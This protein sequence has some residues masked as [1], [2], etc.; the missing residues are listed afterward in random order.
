MAGL[1]IP[2]QTMTSSR[3]KLHPSSWTSAT[4]DLLSPIC[5]IENESSCR[6]CNYMFST[7]Y[8]IQ[9][10]SLSS[11]MKFLTVL[12]L[13][14]L[15]T[16]T[17]C[18]KCPD[19]WTLEE[20]SL[21]DLTIKDHQTGQNLLKIASKY[22][23]RT[24]QI[25]DTDGQVIF[26]EEVPG[27]G[28]VVFAPLPKNDEYEVGIE[29]S[30]MLFIDLYE[31]GTTIHDVDTLL[32]NYQVHLDECSEKEFTFMHIHYNDSLV[33]TKTDWNRFMYI[34]GFK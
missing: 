12:A 4:T 15:L 8:R 23:R 13:L 2:C 9:K 33:Y 10:R 18:N 29:K 21:I 16:L 6:F 25:R 31:A 26:D 34:T 22:D 17:S 28:I 27:D 20:Y 24:F 3:Y 19:D 1:T 7:L 11:S 14:L 5:T 30:T 32:V